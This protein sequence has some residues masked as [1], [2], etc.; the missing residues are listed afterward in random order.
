MDTSTTYLGLK[1]KNPLVVGSCSLTSTPDGARKLEEKGVGALVVRSFFEDEISDAA[2]GSTAADPSAFLRN[3]VEIRNAVAIPVI[4]SLNGRTPARS[5]MLARQ[6][7][8]TGVSALELNLYDIPDSTAHTSASIESHQL[9]LVSAVTAAT[10]LPVTVKISPYYTALVGFCQ[11]LE[12]HGAK[13]IV[14]FNRFMQ[15]D[16][17]IETGHL[18]YNANFS[19]ADDVRLPLRW[20]AILREHIHADIALSGGVHDANAV[21]RALLVGANAVCLCSVLYLRHDANPAGEI[22]G[23]LKHWLAR[24]GCQNIDEFRGTMR[25][26]GL[27]GHAGFERAHYVRTL[28]SVR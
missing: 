26:T 24:K 17:N 9:E 18:R 4:A 28:A 3:L 25:N 12:A 22:L 20:T 11:Q 14:I 1:L 2:P 8:D 19:H 6:I 7:E 15:P 21:I 10:K 16:I 5:A 13:G 27:G 23:D